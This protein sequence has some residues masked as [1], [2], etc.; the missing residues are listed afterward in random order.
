MVVILILLF[1]LF[2]ELGLLFL[3][4]KVDKIFPLFK[5]PIAIDCKPISWQII[6]IY[7]VLGAVLK[8]DDFITLLKS[9]EALLTCA[10][11]L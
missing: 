2:W 3:P 10:N 8:L 6:P 5:S 11:D 9:F 1:K 7:P 4:L